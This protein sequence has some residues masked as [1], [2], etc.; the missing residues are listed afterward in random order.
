MRHQVEKNLVAWM[1]DL[2]TYGNAV[3]ETMP[4][5]STRHIPY[6]RYLEQEEARRRVLESLEPSAFDVP[7]PGAASACR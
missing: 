1:T 7:N 6:Q 4:D 3:M 2:V 5:G